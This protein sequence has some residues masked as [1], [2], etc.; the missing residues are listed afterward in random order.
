MDSRELLFSHYACDVYFNPELKAIESSW[1]GPSAE[2]EE[3][4]TILDSLVEGLKIKSSSIIIAD[5]RKMQLIIPK[6]I[7]WI[8]ENWYPRALNA[9]WRYEALVVTDYTFNS[10]AVRKIVRT[11]D[12]KKLKTAYFK[13]LPGAYEWVKD[14]FEDWL[15]A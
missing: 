15:V 14:G 4:H 11:Y 10:V 5:A 7:E 9:G 3:L 6:D 2:G 12:E 8:S 13:T 1:K